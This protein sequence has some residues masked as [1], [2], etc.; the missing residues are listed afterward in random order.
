M[1][2]MTAYWQQFQEYMDSLKTWVKDEECLRQI[3]VAERL[4]ATGLTIEKLGITEIKEVANQLHELSKLFR[5]EVIYPKDGGHQFYLPQINN[6]ESLI[7]AILYYQHLNHYEQVQYQGSINW[8]RQ[9][10]I[11][12]I[13]EKKITTK[14]QAEALLLEIREYCQKQNISV[15]ES[16]FVK[17]TEEPVKDYTSKILKLLAPRIDPPKNEKKA[18][19][20][21][22]ELTTLKHFLNK[23]QQQEN[24]LKAKA[25]F[26]EKKLTAFTQAKQ[27]HTQL[28]DEWQN[29]RFITKFSFWLIS[30]FREVPQS[31]NI[32]IAQEQVIKAEKELNQELH[33]YTLESY[34]EKLREQ[35]EQ[36]M[37]AK[38]KMRNEIVQK[39][40]IKSMT[41]KGYGISKSQLACISHQEVS[42]NGS[43]KKSH[44]A[45]FNTHPPSR[46]P[47]LDSIAVAVAAA[48]IHH[49]LATNSRY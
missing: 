28:N 39:E 44:C 3:E 7:F 23:L 37:H 12:G 15:N 36:I 6:R 14:I 24:Q 29:K 38:E 18:E 27:Y 20:Q 40:K 4:I 8:F 16:L 17:N 48:S 31:R 45:F 25:D 46:Y 42:S 47:F 2:S 33:P 22:D 21:S 13:N 32:K 5:Y 9:K 41:P 35:Q 11:D 43:F 30:F 49:F 1:I 34:I 26:I 19:N 10:V